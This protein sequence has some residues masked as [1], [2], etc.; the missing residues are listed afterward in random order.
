MAGQLGAPLTISRETP[1]SVRAQ[2]DG[3]GVE[4]AAEA[5]P[6]HRLTLL[7]MYPLGARVSDPRV[8]APPSHASGDVPAAAVEVAA[9]SVTELGLPG[10]VLAGT[11]ARPAQRRGRSPAAGPTWTG[12]RRCTAATASRPTR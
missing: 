3:L 6:P 2:L 5:A 8:A 9:E 7:R 12:A 4:A 1:L 11:G 10:L